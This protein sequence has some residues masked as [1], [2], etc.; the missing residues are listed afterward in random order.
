MASAI[1]KYTY[2]FATRR[3]SLQ[4]FAQQA[5]GAFGE[6]AAAAGGV[7]MPLMYKLPR[8]FSGG[9]RRVL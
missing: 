9:R 3:A 6:V 7:I 2:Y 8:D 4:L 1:L 5:S